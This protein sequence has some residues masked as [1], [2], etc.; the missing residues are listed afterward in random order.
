MTN[1]YRFYPNVDV[2]P[3]STFAFHRDRAS[4]AHFEQQIH[5]SRFAQI[6]SDFAGV[7]RTIYAHKLVEYGK[8]S[9]I[10]LGCGDGGLLQHIVNYYPHVVPR[11]YDF[12]PSNEAAWA[13]RNI[14]SRTRLMNFVDEWDNI[15]EANVY[16]IT[17]VLEHLAD[18]HEM[19]RRIRAR[20]A[21][22]IASSPWG[23]TM[24][25]HDECHAWG[26][27]F[28]GYHQMMR[29]AGFTTKYHHAAGPFQVF[30][31]SPYA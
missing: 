24:M 5:K 3:V 26:W 31:G 1:E 29:D 8:L 13:R 15:P 10:D 20:N 2:P 12:Q 22:I 17:E 28:T 14:S 16:I 7:V 25:S 30:T 4:V 21:F 6:V 23:E 18:P 27:T 9:V 11:G 19:V